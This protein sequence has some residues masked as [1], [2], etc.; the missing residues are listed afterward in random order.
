MFEVSSGNWEKC[1][2]GA[3]FRGCFQFSFRSFC[4]TNG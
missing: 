2:K 4:G 3:R 1:G